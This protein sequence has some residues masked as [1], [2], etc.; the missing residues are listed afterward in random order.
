[1]YVVCSTQYPYN[2]T[3]LLFFAIVQSSGND[4]FWPITAMYVN[5]SFNKD[6]ILVNN[7]CLRTAQKL[8]KEFPRKS[9]NERSLQ[10][11]P[12]ELRHSWVDGVTDQEQQELWRM[13]SCQWP[14]VQGAPET[15]QS[16]ILSNC[17]SS[18][19]CITWSF[20]G[21]PAREYVYSVAN[22]FTFFTKYS[23]A[24]E[25]EASLVNKGQNNVN[26]YAAKSRSMFPKLKSNE[27]F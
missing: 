21:H 5:I 26:K 18:V 27:S 1:M 12:H 23:W 14:L 7:L 10:R 3:Y 25:N 16:E 13:S 15:R 6:H 9:W 22:K 20:L 19:G 4:V 8:M 2:P 17:Q 11:L 24:I